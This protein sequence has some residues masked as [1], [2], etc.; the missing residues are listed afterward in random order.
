MKL[1]LL[2]IN[3]FLF[4]SCAT[5]YFTYSDFYKY[6]EWVNHNFRWCGDDDISK[7]NKNDV[8]IFIG[9]MSLN[10]WGWSRW[11]KDSITLMINNS[12]NIDSF[13]IKE[14][15]LEDAN[16]KIILVKN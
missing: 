2:I 15:V 3:I 1:T 14:L 6:P 4:T 10:P 7:N 13:Y 9:S 12:S 5:P 8:V 16:E 11:S